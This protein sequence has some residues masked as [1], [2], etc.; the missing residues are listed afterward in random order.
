[1]RLAS[2]A[3]PPLLAGP[4][5]GELAL[6]GFGSTKGVIDEA[7]EIL[8]DGI[9]RLEGKFGRGCRETSLHWQRFA[10]LQIYMGDFAGAKAT[11][12]HVQSLMKEPGSG[13]ELLLERG[14]DIH[15]AQSLFGLGDCPGA[16]RA[17]EGLIAHAEKYFDRSYY[18]SFDW[19]L[20]CLEILASCEL[21][22]G[23]LASALE[24]ALQ[25]ATDSRDSLLLAS[26]AM[27]ERQA[28][29]YA[30]AR[31]KG[32]DL[33]LTAVTGSVEP[34][35][36]RRVF[37]ALIRSRALVLDEITARQ[38]LVAGERDPAV[39]ALAQKYQFVTERLANL[40]VRA[41]ESPSPSELS[42]LEQTQRQKEGIERELAAR[43]IPLYPDGIVE[44]IARTTGQGGA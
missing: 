33:A 2:E 8:L 25:A 15:S 24:P 11:M 29:R 17:C 22:A 20:P 44:L 31:S 35:A 32:L 34:R 40:T 23:R 12:E 28:L 6:V 14:F 1:M 39:I 37:D 41:S 7:R 43:G 10:R 9:A 42:I 4:P 16:R 21:R 27:S 30:A 36:R 18:K 13:A 26:R 38:R 19:Y 5:E 3:L